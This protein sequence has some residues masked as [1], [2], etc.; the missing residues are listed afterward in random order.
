VIQDFDFSI[1]ILRALLWQ[2]N[3][4]PRLESLLQSKQ[5]WYDIHESEFWSDWYTDVFD[6]RTANDFGLSVWA[7]ILGVTL[8][9]GTADPGDH[10]P[11]WGFSGDDVNFG[12]GNFAP[13]ASLPLT[14]EQRRVLLRLRY[15]QLTTRGTVPEIN[16]FMTRLFGSQ[17]YV[18]VRD[19]LDMTARYVFGFSLSSDLQVIFDR[20]DALPRP[21]GVYVDYVVAPSAVGWGFGRYHLNFGNGNFNH[22]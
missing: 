6:L 19:G 8:S 4:A 7:I 11:V 20:F 13:W 2:H 12:N 9:N 10:G 16:E 14:T 1:N 21:A 22:G 17:G 3:E 15:F 5:T 18:Y